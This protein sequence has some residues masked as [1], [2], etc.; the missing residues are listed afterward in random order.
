MSHRGVGFEA[1]RWKDVARIYRRLM[2]MALE[3]KSMKA[4]VAPKVVRQN[5]YF[6]PKICDRQHGFRW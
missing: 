1:D 4:S 6:C 2:G 3:G 5:G